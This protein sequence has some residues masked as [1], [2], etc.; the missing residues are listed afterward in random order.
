MTPAPAHTP[1]L[2]PGIASP[3]DLRALPE[4]ALPQVCA[5]LRTF[6]LE[7]VARTG[8]H[9]ASNLGSVEL[10]VALHYVFDTPTDEIV[11]DTGHQAYP[12]KI[13]T[14]RRSQFDTIR[15]Y[16]GL[17]G[18]PT[19]EESRF[20]TFP[21]GHAGTSVSVALGLA[22]A[23]DTL[24]GSHHVAAVIGDGA[25]T[26]GLA[27]EGLN[28]AHGLRSFLVVLNDNEMSI[29][30]T[31]GSLARHF[32]KLVSNPNYRLF[33]HQMGSAVSGIP[34]AGPVLA[35]IASR[36]LGGLKHVIVPQNVFENLG[37]HYVG[38]I[39]AHDVAELISMIRACRAEDDVPVLLH[40]IT[41]KG[42]GYEPAE[43]DP[44]RYHGVTKFDTGNGDPQPADDGVTYTDLLSDALYRATQT[45][46]R[47]IVVSA[48]MCGGI[49]MTRFAREFPARFV[50]VGIAEQHAVTFA[51]ALAARGMRPVVGIY[52]TFLQRAYDEILHDV[53]LPKVPVLFV[54]DRAGLVGPDG[55]THHGVFDIAYL[56][57]MPGLRIFMPRDKAAMN[58]CVT[59][60]LGLDGPVAIR[61]PRCVV[62][63]KLVPGGLP[64][65][66]NN[67]P[68]RWESLMSGD[69]VALI[70]IGHMVFYA[71]RAAQQLAYQGVH[72]TVIDA[73]GLWPTDMDALAAAARR[74]G[75]LVTI[76]D[77]VVAGGFGSSVAESLARAGIQAQLLMI[78][79]PNRFVEHGSLSDLY[80]EL[81][82]QPDQL[83]ARI[84]SW[85]A[86]TRTTSP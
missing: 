69:D 16:H 10:A 35:R 68:A 62:P 86:S 81:G 4:H 32:S 61:Y 28:N 18:Y 46:D 76:E 59:H 71:Y 64:P 21:V 31:I 79:I 7:H 83:A 54:I 72:A 19:P 2:L 36:L 34:L 37:F 70:S 49:G 74:T 11:W 30:P 17:S 23:R 75:R 24:R 78:G 63:S 65:F 58:L 84:G 5:E 12:H 14:G 56:R 48:A 13:L 22:K 40:V 82:W 20:D 25:M 57:H 3:A 55:K 77:H 67:D 60:A 50:D 33:K 85:L 51:G 41:K 1:E 53:C 73:C 47:I 8:G 27:L 43:R 45:N 44:E 39:D 6:I 80:T 26:S 52:S 9:L 15:T 42:K 38:P 66:G 29:S